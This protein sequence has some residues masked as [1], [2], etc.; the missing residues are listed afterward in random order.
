M[1]NGTD[2]PLGKVPALKATGPFS[3]YRHTFQM[4]QMSCNLI[5]QDGDG[6]FVVT[7]VENRN[8]RAQDVY[9][10]E[11]VGLSVSPLR[12]TWRALGAVAGDGLHMY[13]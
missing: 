4:E 12:S 5:P 2:G 9:L 10:C 6:E 7:A 3:L 13:R 11:M 1:L 8:R